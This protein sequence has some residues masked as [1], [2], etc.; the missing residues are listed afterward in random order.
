MALTSKRTKPS[1]ES[2]KRNE[3]KWT[4]TLME[5]GWTVLPSVIL[6]RQKALGLDAVDINIL[7]HLVRHWWFAESLPHPAKKT[8]AE[9]MNINESTVRRHIAGMEKAGFIKRQSRYDPTHGQMTNEYDFGGLIEEVKPY[10]LE[11][12]EERKQQRI[13]SAAKRIRKKPILKVVPG[14]EN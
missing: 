4:P 13:Q 11:A 9:C 7:M 14:D 5:A 8:I 1:R 12:I 6:E 2:L 3:S 10:A